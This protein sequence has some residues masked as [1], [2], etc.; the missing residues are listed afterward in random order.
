MP[1]IHRTAARRPT[2]AC[3]DQFVPRIAAQTDAIVNITTGGSTR[4]TWTSGWPIR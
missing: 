3:F 1:A 2:P 4:M